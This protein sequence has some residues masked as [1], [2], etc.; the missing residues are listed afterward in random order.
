MAFTRYHDDPLRI[1][2]QMQEF[3]DPG[4]YGLQVPGNGDRMPYVADPQLRLQKWG[5]NRHGN[6]VQIESELLGMQ[7]ILTRDCTPSVAVNAFPMTYP[8]DKSEVT[9]QPRTLAPAW[10]IRSVAQPR[11]ESLRE[12]V[13]A[14]AIVPFQTNSDTRNSIRD[15]FRSVA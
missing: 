5:A 14:H 13:Q 1:M 3:T 6:F 2:K 4:V 11:W 9:M 12:D 10:E 7:R 15:N 8:V